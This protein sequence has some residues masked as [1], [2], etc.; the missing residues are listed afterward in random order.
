LSTIAILL[1]RSK[2][3]QTYVWL[4]IMGSE[5]LPVKPSATGPGPVGGTADAAM[6]RP[7]G[8]AIAAQQ[9]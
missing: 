6:E 7:A 4:E 2:N 1:Y 5:C 8:R 3:K 9:V